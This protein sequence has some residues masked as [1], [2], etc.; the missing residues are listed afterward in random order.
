MCEDREN[1]SRDPCLR[2]GL[3]SNL[4]GVPAGEQSWV[5][6]GEP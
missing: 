6:V 5:L 1:G 2:N 4:P 3:Q